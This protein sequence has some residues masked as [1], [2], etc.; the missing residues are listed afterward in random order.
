MIGASNWHV[1]FA[2]AAAEL[3][4]LSARVG[5]MFTR[6]PQ[7]VDFEGGTFLFQ[8]GADPLRVQPAAGMLLLYTADESNTHSVEPVTAGE[9]TTLTMWFTIDPEHNEDRK[10]CCCVARGRFNV[11]VPRATFA[12]V[13]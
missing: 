7:G 5:G 10:V 9:R 12:A 1:A 2:T 11:C 4:K 6:V 13:C 3:L 8:S